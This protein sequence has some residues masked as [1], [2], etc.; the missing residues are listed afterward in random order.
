MDRKNSGAGKEGFRSVAIELSS[1][2]SIE[3]INIANISN[4]RLLSTNFI[5]TKQ[6][7]IMVTT[8]YFVTALLGFACLFYNVTAQEI[9]N[10]TYFYGLSPPVYP[11]RTFFASIISFVLTKHLA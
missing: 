10:D 11:S 5:D 2:N 8:N 1:I 4:R 9:T 6:I 3:G 7:V